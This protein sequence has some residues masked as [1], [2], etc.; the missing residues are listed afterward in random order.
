MSPGAR[1]RVA[2][3][4]R[5][6]ASRTSASAC[7]ARQSAILDGAGCR[8]PGRGGAH[9]RATGSAPRSTTT[10]SS[11][12][13]T[14]S[15][16]W[17]NYPTLADK[18]VNN[19]AL[20]AIDSATGEIVAYVGSVDYYNRKDPRVQGQFDVAG[21]GVRQPGSAFKP[22]VYSSAFRSR[23]ATPATFFVDAVTQFGV[24]SRDELHADQRRH[25][26]PWA[27]A[28]GRRSPLL[29]QRAVGDDAVP[30]WR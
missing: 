28:G 14:G 24:R 25:Q 10:Y 19:G 6:C 2:A 15:A 16:I 4:R 11:W 30:G 26:G 22:I 12:P 1:C 21:L 5:S 20:V 7:S 13:R 18:N 17:V 23:E 29:A 9:R 3:S 27:A 8:Q